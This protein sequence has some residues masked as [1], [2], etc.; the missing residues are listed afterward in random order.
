VRRS[1]RDLIFWGTGSGEDAPSD[2]LGPPW[3]GTAKRHTGFKSKNAPEGQPPAR[4]VTIGGASG[5]G[6]ELDLALFCR[7]T[8]RCVC[9]TDPGCITGLRGSSHRSRR[10]RALK[11]SR[12]RL[13]S[14]AV[15]GS[16]TGVQTA[17][18][19]ASFVAVL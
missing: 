18:T 14:S 8:S 1:K 5:D 6:R 17:H 12:P 11:P 7:T 4:L 16:G 3:K 2:S 15:P 9:V 13:K 10:L 19:T